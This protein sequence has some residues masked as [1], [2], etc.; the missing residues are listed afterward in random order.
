MST[1]GNVCKF[2]RVAIG[3]GFERV[4]VNVNYVEIGTVSPTVPRI[5]KI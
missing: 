2:I 5:V 3:H 4:K 1:K